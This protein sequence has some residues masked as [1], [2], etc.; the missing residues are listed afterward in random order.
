MY[1]KQRT[2]KRE[3]RKRRVRQK[4]SRERTVP[5]LS[6]FRSN[7]HIYAQVIDDGK[8]VTLFAASD[9]ELSKEKKQSL[10]NRAYEVG[11]LLANKA[12]KKN[13]T[14]VVFDRNRYAYKGAVAQ[15]AK[16][17]RERGLKF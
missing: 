17:A 10:R 3:R 12:Q 7:T 16:G 5:R 11:K 14:K 8:G 2:K 6:V 4:I 15:L 1:I 13:I 9:K